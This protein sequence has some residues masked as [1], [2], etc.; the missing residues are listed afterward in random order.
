MGIPA[1]YKDADYFGNVTTSLP[2]LML[3]LPKE[4]L[5]LKECIEEQV[6]SHILTKVD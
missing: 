2:V 3:P 5:A 1:D 6:N 4:Q